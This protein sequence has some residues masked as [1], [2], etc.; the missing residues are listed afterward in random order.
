M[1]PK[2]TESVTAQDFWKA[3]HSQVSK[4]TEHYLVKSGD[5][6][7]E[8]ITAQFDALLSRARQEA[9]REALESRTFSFLGKIYEYEDFVKA[10]QNHSRREAL[11]EMDEAQL[12]LESEVHEFGKL[13]N[14]NM[15]PASL[16]EAIAKYKKLRQEYK[17]N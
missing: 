12:H 17:T 8:N 14:I 15:W 13:A 11:K 3:F 9:R 16:S 7:V 1:T 10:I 5:D 6:V 4:L 2:K